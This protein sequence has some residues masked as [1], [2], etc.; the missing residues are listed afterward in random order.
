LA[1]LGVGRHQASATWTVPGATAASAGALSAG[2]PQ[3]VR[4]SV[5]APKAPRIRV[6]LVIMV[7][8]LAQV[9]IRQP[10][11]DENGPALA[12]EE[13]GGRR[14]AGVGHG[15]ELADVALVGQVA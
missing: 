9:S 15:R 5:R 6:C 7:S 11:A 13:D 3:A 10:Q 14:R 4:A 2:W 1:P 8:I 12:G